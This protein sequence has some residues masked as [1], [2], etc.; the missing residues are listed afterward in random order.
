MS[1][2]KMRTDEPDGKNAPEKERENMHED[3][4]EPEESAVEYPALDELKSQLA[5]AQ[6]QANEYKDGWQRSVADFQNYKRRTD[7]ERAETYQVAVGNII[8]SYLPVMDDLERALANRPENL[9]WAEGIELICR[10]L[11]TILESEGLKRIDA[12]GKMFDPN[13]HEAISQEDSAEQESGY[14]IAVIRNGY[15]L[16]DKVIRPAMVRV[17]R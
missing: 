6:A 9:P 3:Y 10:K 4:T 14:V 11:Q 1:N 8:R 13:L 5:A 16:G 17:A 2:K 15:M 7:A 12:V